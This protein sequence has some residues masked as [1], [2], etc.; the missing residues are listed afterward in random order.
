MF[1][2]AFAVLAVVCGCGR[3]GFDAVGTLGDGGT[4]GDGG[5]PVSLVLPDG[6][7]IDRIAL[8]PGG[9]WYADAVS[10]GMWRSTVGAVAVGASRAY[11][12]TTATATNN[13]AVS[14]AN[15]ASLNNWN[16]CFPGGGFA[17]AVDPNDDRHVVFAPY[18]QL[19]QTE[20]AFGGY[21]LDKQQFDMDAGNVNA[22]AF[23]AASG[24][25]AVTMRGV[26][27]ASDRTL[28]WQA[29]NTG[30]AAWDVNDIVEHGGDLYLPTQ[31]GVMRSAG[32]SE[33]FTISTRGMIL[34]TGG[35]NLAFAP[36]GSLIAGSRGIWRSPDNGQTWTDLYC[37]RATTGTGPA[38]S[39]STA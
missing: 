21:E 9:T 6:G 34:S 27:F 11:V 3:L 24:L 4:V 16:V 17:L 5:T 7:E 8:A 22:L 39:P 25:V 35:E 1:C 37:R 2:W 38:R 31:G 28:H 26:F 33:P 10:V 15:T 20:D 23:T 14:C 29:R 13:G 32:G 19:G 12:Q 18:D 36:D 30:L